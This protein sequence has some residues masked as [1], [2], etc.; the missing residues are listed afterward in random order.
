LKIGTLQEMKTEELNLFYRNSS[1]DNT[2]LFLLIA[3][4]VSKCRQ[5]IDR[6]TD[7]P[8]DTRICVTLKVVF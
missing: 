2:H 1:C 7:R 5:Q 6:Q 4:V 8:R 3:F